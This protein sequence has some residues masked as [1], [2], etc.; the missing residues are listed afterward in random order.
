MT[1]FLT[2]LT[3]LEL[4]LTPKILWATFGLMLF[5][6]LFCVSVYLH[7]SPKYQDFDLV[8]MLAIDQVTGRVSD[9][10]TRINLA[11]FVT[12]W[13]FVYLVMNDKF[14]E[15]YFFGFM[16]AWV[17]D[18]FLSRKSMHEGINDIINAPRS[19]NQVIAD[20]KPSAE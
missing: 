4:A 13:A 11:F 9:S 14:T 5:V 2:F 19:T 6:I 15:W 7:L 16:G 17:T 18:R 10:K 3:A 1:E 12:C 20:R 8:E